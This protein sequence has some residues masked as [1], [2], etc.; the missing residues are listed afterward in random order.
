MRWGVGGKQREKEKERRKER[1]ESNVN[2]S[3]VI[4]HFTDPII[5]RIQAR[6]NR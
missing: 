1:L 2:N 4:S 6:T 3:D 5:L